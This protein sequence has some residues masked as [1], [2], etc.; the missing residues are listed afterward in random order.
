[1][2]TLGDVSVRLL[3]IGVL[4]LIIAAIARAAVAAEGDQAFVTRAAM[5]GMAE[6]EMGKLAS[7]KA[8]SSAV[9]KFAEQMISDH[10]KVN[11]KL[12]TMAT[13]KSLKVPNAL[14]AEHKAK[15]EMLSKKSGAQFDN[16]YIHAQVAGHQK[17][18]ELLNQE[19]KN[20]ADADLKA[21][22]EKHPSDRRTA[23]QDG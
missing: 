11:E 9:K 18:Q 20:G 16:A 3:T 2:K 17:M 14:D 7:E 6:V 1:M 19:A 21:F 4:A 15:V 8:S 13:G 10:T 22:A 23:L 12:E 5:G